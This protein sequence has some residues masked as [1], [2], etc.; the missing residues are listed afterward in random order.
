[1]EENEKNNIESESDIELA[2]RLARIGAFIIDSLIIYIPIIVLTLFFTSI[3][4]DIYIIFVLMQTTIYLLYFSILEGSDYQA[5][6]GKKLL[7]MK[8]CDENFE[9]ISMKT[10]INRTLCKLIPYAVVVVLFNENNQ[11]LHDRICKTLVVKA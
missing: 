9:R 1:M 4:N 8:V 3:G 11:G 6:L 5:T 7:G 10:A 2:S